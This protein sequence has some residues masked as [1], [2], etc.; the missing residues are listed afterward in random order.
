[1][2]EEA[3]RLIQIGF[4]VHPLRK[5]SKA[6][7]DSDWTDLPVAS[8]KAL[9]RR[10]NGQ[11][12][13]IGVRLGEPSDIGG[14]FLYCL[15]IDI[16]D[17]N[18]IDEALSAARRYLPSLDNM[19]TVMTGSGGESR[20]VYFVSDGLFKSRK[21]LHSHAK[22][23]D[24]KGK[25]HWAWEIEFYGT[26]KQVVLPPSVH[27]DTGKEYYWSR[28]FNTRSVD[29]VGAEPFIPASKIKHWEGH[30]DRREI[31]DE[32]ALEQAVRQA[33][34]GLT[35]REIERALDD[36]P[37][38]WLDDYELWLKTGM[39]LSHEFAD[40]PETG[41]DLWHW[42]SKRSGKYE[43]DVL[44]DKWE[45]FKGNKS[46]T[47]FRTIIEAANKERKERTLEEFDAPGDDEERDDSWRKRLDFNADGQ[48]KSLVHNL[49][50]ILRN[51]DRIKGLI[52]FNE[53]LQ[54]PV[55]LRT[56]EALVPSMNDFVC[57][58]PINGTRWIDKH[59]DNLRIFLES[60]RKQGGYGL[61]V[62]DRDLKAAI[63]MAAHHNTFH[64][65]RE[66]LSKLEWDEQP[67]IADLFYTYLGS[68]D[69]EY[70]QAIA[71]LFMIGAVA[72]VFEPGCKFD[73]APIIEG[74]QGKR[75]TTFAE[76]LAVNQEWFGGLAPDFHNPQKMV[77]SMLGK[78]ILEIPE[79]AGF[80]K[81]D[82][83]SIKYFFSARK[84]TTRLSYD[85][86]PSDFPRACIFIGTTN[87]NEYLI[88]ETGNRRYWPVEINVD[89]INIEELRKN[90]DQLWAESVDAF[91]RMRRGQPHGDLPLYIKNKE[92][93]RIAEV[94]QEKRRDN[95]TA[96][97]WAQKI[98]QWLDTPLD[99]NE[100][101]DLNAN[102]L[103]YRNETTLLE[104][105]TQCLGQQAAQYDTRHGKNLGSAMK[106]LS[107]T[108]KSVGTRNK[109]KTW[110]R[111][112]LRTAWPKPPRKSDLV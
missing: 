5:K 100:F 30:T 52:G 80:N 105:W 12:Y 86:R 7:I 26:G 33:P 36:L 111:I 112:G 22:V 63:N 41:L 110:Q 53:L 58:D 43:A 65:V 60:R 10:F 56:V 55:I 71:R 108:W 14:R 74:K 82:I 38:E 25:P 84:D 40:D 34:T 59:D 42:A 91:R 11:S 20:H 81:T 16:R 68:P 47:T 50:L 97:I 31:A 46:P 76:T 45:S 28:P 67:R 51:D 87:D 89:S 8:Y 106:M 99:E 109:A 73:F 70:T 85:R 32:D 48:I 37:D 4:A 49:V 64:P 9:Q 24:A 18:L 88:D 19:P 72:R 95:S 44:D 79:L 1:M 93:A 62:A 83:R 69:N 21:L 17:P 78:W 103:Q 75:K 2:L 102:G 90:V 3:E 23:K 57:R 6:P 104:V 101:T 13:N 15:D 39:A 35:V 98:T 94:E 92:A 27:P 77:E 96:S 29:L 66:Y 54:G 107:E 61:K